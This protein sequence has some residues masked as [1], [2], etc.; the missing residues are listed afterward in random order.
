LNRL[1]GLI[2]AAGAGSRMGKT[3][4][5]VERDGGTYVSATIAALA[6]HVARAHVVIGDR[7][8]EVR[9]VHKALDV[10]WI[11]AKGWREGMGRSLAIGIE[12]LAADERVQS[13]FVT[14]CDLPHLDARVAGELVR[15]FRETSKSVVACSYENVI[16]VP[17]LFPRPW[18]DRLSSCSGD[19]GARDLL[20]ASTAEI[21]VFPWPAGALDSDLPESGL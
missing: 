6:P 18:F 15:C 19:R 3:K 10:S 14:P 4:A 12:T 21:E 2:L 20:R 8:E 5:L 17:A 11:D 13:V 7:A 1:H 9:S 16:G